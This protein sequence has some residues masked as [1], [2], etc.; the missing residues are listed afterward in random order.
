MSFSLHFWSRIRLMPDCTSMQTPKLAQT[1]RPTTIIYNS[2]ASPTSTTTNSQQAQTYRRM[3]AICLTFV[4][5]HLSP[6]TEL[7]LLHI[8]HI[9]T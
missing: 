6:E 2:M 9:E 5:W 8:F 3:R 7:T 4:R 1:K